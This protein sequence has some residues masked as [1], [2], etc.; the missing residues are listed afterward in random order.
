MSKGLCVLDNETKQ[1]IWVNYFPL[2]LQ[3][4]NG[5]GGEQ[6]YLNH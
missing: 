1:V 2:K 6:N 5:V 4:A 3:G